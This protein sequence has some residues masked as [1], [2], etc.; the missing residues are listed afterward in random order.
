MMCLCDKADNSYSIRGNI[1]TPVECSCKFYILGVW[2]P[3]REEL[4]VHLF[5]IH[6]E[7]VTSYEVAACC[8]VHTES[9]CTGG[10]QIVV[11]NSC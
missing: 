6:N 10:L 3:R 11:G 5:I 4:F 1:W 8:G 2:T 7:C 9:I